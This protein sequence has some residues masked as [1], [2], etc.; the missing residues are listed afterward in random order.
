MF[1]FRELAPLMRPFRHANLF[2]RLLR[3]EIVDRTSGTVLGVLWLILQPGLQVFAFW[4]LL[5]FVL[6]V[7]SHGSVSYLDYF[8]AAMIPWMLLQESLV[9]SL[10]VLSEYKSLYQKT[11]FPV[12]LLPLIPLAMSLLIYAPVYILVIGFRLGLLSAGKA[13]IISAAMTLWLIP[14]CYLFAVLGLFIRE[15][16]QLVPFG[17][18]LL[19]YFTPILY[20]PQALPAEL[21]DLLSVNVLADVIAVVE[22]WLFGDPVTLRNLGQPLLLW[23]FSVPMARS[24]YRRAAPL[25]REAL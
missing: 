5:D 9:R 2:L 23:I 10:G 16:R 24:I 12:E 18:T 14:A 7:R 20:Q 22:G 15:S 13:L 19:L 6:K 3:R 17:L 25:F 4:F 8:L 11:V 21:R 1:G